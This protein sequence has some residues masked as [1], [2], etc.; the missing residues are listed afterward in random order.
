MKGVP[1]LESLRRY[2]L[3]A[4]IVWLRPDI[5][6]FEFGT[7]AIDRT[8]LQKAL[9]S[10]I[11]TSFRGYDINFA[12]LEKSDYYRDVWRSS[13]MIH[14]LGEDLLRRARQRGFND[15][16]RYVL[17]PAAIDHEFFK[18]GGENT[19]GVL[20]SA[21]HPLRILSVGRLEWKKG[22]EFAL[23]A[24]ALL[25]DAGIAAVYEIIGDG[26]YFEPLAYA[27][28]QFGLTDSVRFLGGLPREEVRARMY[29]ADVFLHAA[30]SEG[31]CNAVIEA[32][33]M[34]LPVVTSDADGLRENVA[35]GLSGFVVPRR[36]SQ[37]LAGRLAELARTPALRRTMG[38]EGRR[39]VEKYFT[40]A[41]QVSA[42]ESMYR[43]VASLPPDA[44]TSRNARSDR[45]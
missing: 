21:K 3:D 44:G 27:R 7:L 9:G 29:E 4:P 19:G 23:A 5:V 18:P 36:S 45:H 1:F 42:F 43:T 26:R 38:K 6:H 30:V 41:A 32:Q 10:K 15:Q 13:D 39:R 35:D 34:E 20:G 8:H 14:F 33:A 11:V 16:T 12:G 25:R 2:Y 37:A 40:I 17:V 28:A 31:F 24:V 22:Y